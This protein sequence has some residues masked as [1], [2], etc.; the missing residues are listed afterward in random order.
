MLYS[1]SCQCR[2]IISWVSSHQMFKYHWFDLYHTGVNYHNFL[3]HLFWHGITESKGILDRQ[4]VSDC[5]QKIQTC[6]QCDDEINVTINSSPPHYNGKTRFPWII[7]VILHSLPWK[8]LKLTYLEHL[9][10]FIAAWWACQKWGCEIAIWNDIK[11][12][13]HSGHST[14]HSFQPFCILA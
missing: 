13:D 4:R 12:I 5:N 3:L 9:S 8:S 14:L 11:F 7:I 2:T 1:G 10:M 6:Y